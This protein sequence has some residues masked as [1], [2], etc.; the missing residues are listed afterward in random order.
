MKF[1][2]KKIIIDE[3]GYIII[4]FLLSLIHLLF[5]VV[6]YIGLLKLIKNQRI[7]GALK[8]MIIV[9]M[10]G[11]LSTAVGCSLEPLNN[12]KLFIFI[13]LSMYV[14]N[15]G[16]KLK[17]TKVN[18]INIICLI[19][20]SYS[21][22][23]SVIYGSYPIVSIFKVVSFGIIFC[24]V[25]IGVEISRKNIDWLKYLFSVMTP[26]F[27][28]SI[29]IIP[30][31]KFRI[32]NSNFQGV[33]N[34]VNMFGILAA[35]YLTILLGTKKVDTRYKNIMIFL[36]LIMQYLSSS[37][38]GLLMSIIALII[39]FVINRHAVT[40]Y[41]FVLFLIIC[42]VGIYNISPVF[43]EQIDNSI[44]EFVYKGNTEDILASRRDAQKQ[45]KEKYDNNKLFGSGFMVPFE[46]DKISL[47]FN[48]PVN[49]EPGNLIWSLVGDVGIIG[50]LIFIVLI[51]SILILGNFKFIILLITSIGVCMG[52]MVFFSVNNMSIL[53]YIL[54]AIFL[55]IT[56]MERVNR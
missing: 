2:N 3:N 54:I 47:A 46:K 4:L 31:D 17:L 51:F 45:A 33:F 30:F 44:I 24:A 41:F 56:N 10:R 26:F 9:T 16:L 52:E 36:T 35:I 23:V 49:V 14:I 38:T 42:A 7:I 50:L 13:I 18:L 8:Y 34:H 15:K 27:V 6:F 11:V 21:I 37:R 39:N 28:V 25:L 29:F 20:C 22:I 1:K 32:I 48:S 53:L 19:F 5:G 43:K 55:T 12:L 40:T